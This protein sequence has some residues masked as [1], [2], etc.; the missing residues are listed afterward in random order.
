LKS[1]II[2]SLIMAVVSVT[3][4]WWALSLQL[5]LFTWPK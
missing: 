3:V 1:A 4:F 2:L 5:P